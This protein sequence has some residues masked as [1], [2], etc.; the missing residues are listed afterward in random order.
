[1]GG[2]DSYFGS[3]ILTTSIDVA[4]VVAFLASEDSGYITGASVEVTGMRRQLGG[5]GQK[6]DLRD[7]GWGTSPVHL[8]T[9]FCP[10]QEVFSCNTSRTPDSAAPPPLHRPPTDE[11]S[12]PG[13]KRG[14]QC[15]T[16]ECRIWEAGVLVTLINS[17]SSSLPPPVL[18]VSKPSD[19]SPPPPPFPFPQDCSLSLS[20]LPGQPPPPGVRGESVSLSA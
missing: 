18:L 14:G 5:K 6:G 11:D 7:G 19:P 17:K 13:H 4:D 20:G 10:S 15:M 2:D 12:F 9:C 1:M 16:Q 8:S 3:L